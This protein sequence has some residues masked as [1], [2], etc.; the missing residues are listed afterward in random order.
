[1]RSPFPLAPDGSATRPQLPGSLNTNRR[2]SQWL[3][4]LP[5]G[6]LHSRYDLPCPIIAAPGF[7]G[8]DMSTLFV[9]TGW[10]PGVTRSEDEPH[11]GGAL[12]A[13]ET[14]FR[15]IPEPVFAL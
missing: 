7:G 8:P 12:F 14:G 6:T 5:D 9:A 3:R 4:F 2:L 10:S 1:M 11:N 13:M 15:G